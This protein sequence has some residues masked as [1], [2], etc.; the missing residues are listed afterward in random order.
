[1]V[2]PSIEPNASTPTSSRSFSYGSAITP[3]RR[4][5]V[6]VR[7]QS[8]IVDIGAWAR[9]EARG[10]DQEV[11]R[12]LTGAD[13]TPL[14][15]AGRR[16]WTLTNEIVAE[17]LSATMALP[18]LTPSAQLALPFGVNDYVDFYASRTH[19]ENVGRIFRPSSP[20]LPHA[21]L[22]LPIGYHGRTGSIV[23]SGT[24]IRRPWGLVES[25][26]Q[27]VFQPTTKLD[28]EAEI[29]YVV[30]VPST[31][32]ESIAVADLEEHVFGVCVVNDWSARDVQAFEYVPLG[33][34]LGKSFA[35]SVSAWITPLDQLTAC[36]VPAPSQARSD[37][38]SYLHENNPGGLDLRL[39]VELNGQ[40][41]SEP[42]YA[43]MYWTPAQMLAHT[44][45]NGAPVRTGDLFASGTVSGNAPDQYGSLLELTR[46]AREPLT[47]G[48]G[49]R[50]YLEDGDHVVIRAK[51]HAA[52][53]SV[54]DLHE[55]SGTVLPANIH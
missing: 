30:G 46:D 20:E 45:V 54:M 6:V 29:G 11:S 34:F 4:R 18:T 14:L 28:I 42:R 35:T 2:E 25:N 47:T 8:R 9:T 55:V 27:T 21:W 32:G 51:G 36:R 5:T 33:P 19:A 50:G 1:M 52:D 40:T 44:T 24:P 13:L 41:I 7:Q 12:A 48:R 53:G 37:L 22:T 38:A 15:K 43:E 31:M 26:G 3:D 17:A 39:T 23:A 10:L 49:P 16:V